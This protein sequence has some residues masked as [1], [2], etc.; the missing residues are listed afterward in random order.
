MFYFL[1]YLNLVSPTEKGNLLFGITS[2][3]LWLL[4]SWVLVSLLVALPIFIDLLVTFSC[5]LLTLNL[6][7]FVKK[8]SP[9]SFLFSSGDPFFDISLCFYSYN[10]AKFISSCRYYLNSFF[11]LFISNFY[12]FDVIFWNFSRN[13]TTVLLMFLRLLSI[14]EY[15]SIL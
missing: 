2:S 4:I 7:Y 13:D 8:N 15:L 5:F 1:L 3:G 11:I 6:F 12:L 10:S 9:F 14:D